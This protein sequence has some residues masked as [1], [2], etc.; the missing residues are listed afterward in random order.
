MLQ[1]NRSTLTQFLIEERRRFPQAS[2]DFNALIL[3]VTLACKAIA[4]TVAY[5]ELGGAMGNYAPEAGGSVNVQGE[6]QKKLDVLSNELFMQRT[7]WSGH[8]AGMASEEMDLPHQIPAQYPRGPYL[9]VFDPLDGSSNIDVNVS[10]GSIFSVLRAPKEVIDSGRDVVEADFFQ[11]GAAQVAAGYALY[12]PTTMLILTVG[13][14]VNGFTLDPNL[15]EFMLTHP[16]LQVPPDTQEFAINASNSRFWE[17][18]IKRYVDECLAGKT[19]VRGKD[20]NMRWIASMVAEAHRI[21]MRGGV[22]M[23]PRDNKDPSKPGRLR[24]LYEANPI[25]MIMEQA[26]GRASTGREPM[27]EVVPTSLHQRIGL[28]FGSKN[29]VERIERY[30]REPAQAKEGEPLFASRSLFRN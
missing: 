5:G 3:D 1:T 14:G 16:H 21:L 7:E 13:R 2:G 4:R 30:H 26:G 29:E 18:P 8:L 20:F 10:V 9:L 19:G 28:V 12:G 22:F 24:L 6:T 27:M 11:P 23:Y 25:G 15:G 17:A